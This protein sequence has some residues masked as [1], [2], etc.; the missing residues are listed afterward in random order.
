MP[1]RRVVSVSQTQVQYIH[2]AFRRIPFV[3]SVLVQYTIGITVGRPIVKSSKSTAVRS[4][5]SDFNLNRVI[6]ARFTNARN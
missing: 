2:F 4:L 5:S 6:T 3:S 1:T